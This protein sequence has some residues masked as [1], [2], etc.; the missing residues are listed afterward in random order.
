MSTL[1]P[2]RQV[3][4]RA[5][6][7]GFLTGRL[8][9]KLEKLKPDDPKHA[10]LRQ[11]FD[12]QTWL[13]D[14]ARR[15]VQLQAVTHAQPVTYTLKLLRPE[16]KGTSL[17]IAPSSLPSLP[18]VGS[19]CLGEHAD[20][21]VI[22]NAAALDVYQ[23]LKLEHTGQ[24][25]L[26]LCE[27]RDPDLAAVLSPESATAEAWMAAFSGLTVARGKT[28][29]RTNAKQLFWLVG[30]DPH[31]D[32]GYHLLAPLYPTSLVHRVYATVQDDRFSDAAKAAR[33]A[34][35]DGTHSERP[36]HEY[37]DLAIQKL[38]GSNQQNISQLNAKRHGVNY[39]FASLPPNWRSLA[40]RPLLGVTSL[41]DRFGS[42]RPVREP[43]TKLRR[44]L[45]SNP[46]S[47]QATRA[48]VTDLVN[49]LVDELL[50][51]SA[52][53]RSLPPGWSQLPECQLSAAQRHW[54]DPWAPATD[55]DT[56]QDADDT[57]NAIADQFANWLNHRLRDPLPVGDPEFAAWRK[58]ALDQINS[59]DWEQRD[60]E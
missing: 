3:E 13:D 34:R 48:H 42:R 6:V 57:A 18:L 26:S 23:F 16:N 27:A 39:L 17:L 28:S 29:S 54:L 25:L 40:V 33:Q 37:T 46:A 19:H 32:A 22:G 9:S 41:F 47:N 4:L 31:D 12:P 45:E 52:E 2:G 30:Q 36:V 14:A 44:F 49:T 38:G 51:F 53:L 11:Q 58:L 43:A 21:D 56:P 24:T 50:Y 10:E 8:D 55:G 5:V 35:R 20:M 15:V 59:D 7:S 1:D 60:D